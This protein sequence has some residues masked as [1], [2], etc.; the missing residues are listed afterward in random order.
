MIREIISHSEEETFE[1]GNNLSKILS[2]GDVVGFKGGLGAGKTILI[3]GILEGLGYDSRNVVSASF[4]IAQEYKVKY[5][6]VHI[7]L[8]RFENNEEIHY[9]DWDS[10]V[11]LD[12][13]VLIEWSEKVKDFL[14]FSL[15]IDINFI[16]QNEREIK[17]DTKII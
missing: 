5:P 6:V 15:K 13:L 11:S 2:P 16:S 10:Y 7:D 14:N 3:K 8:Y 12:K 17:F 9:I 1:I 4:V